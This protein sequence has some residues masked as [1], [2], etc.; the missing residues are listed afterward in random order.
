MLDI[1]LYAVFITT[2]FFFARWL[3]GIL[4]AA[5]VALFRALVSLAGTVIVVGA[6]FYLVMSFAS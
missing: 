6:I 1:L 4:A 2:L 5:L 3:L